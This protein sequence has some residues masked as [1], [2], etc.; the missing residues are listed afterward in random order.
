MQMKK[1]H[2]TGNYVYNYQTIMCVIFSSKL[3]LEVAFLFF[4]LGGGSSEYQATR[5]LQGIFLFLL[6]RHNI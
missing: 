2:I 4:F 6:A 3:I 5:F 1:E